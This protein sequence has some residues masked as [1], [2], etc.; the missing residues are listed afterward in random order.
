MYKHI[1]MTKN[2]NNI[3]KEAKNNENWNNLDEERR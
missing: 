1:E 3:I 2:I